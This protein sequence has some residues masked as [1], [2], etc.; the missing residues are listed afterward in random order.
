[1]PPT[2]R[3]FRTASGTNHDR[4]CSVTTIHDTCD[5]I[6]G[7]STNLFPLERSVS[8]SR[9]TEDPEDSANDSTVH[10]KFSGW[11]PGFMDMSPR[12][13]AVSHGATTCGPCTRHQN[14]R[15]GSSTKITGM[16]RMG[17][18]GPTTSTMPRSDEDRAPAENTVSSMNSMTS[19]LVTRGLVPS[20]TTISNGDGQYTKAPKT[21]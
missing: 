1:M 15:N 11:R 3:D 13:V 12:H 5:R 16:G 14:A 17:A 21:A 7:P 9:V 20:A 8:P 2:L 18:V 19:S 6:S 4:T 10:V